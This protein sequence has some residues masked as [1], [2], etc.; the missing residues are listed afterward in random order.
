[1]CFHMWFE[2]WVNGRW[3]TLD[4]TLGQGHVG[5]GHVKVLDAHWNDTDSFLPLLPVVR[6]LGKLK[7]DVLSVEYQPSA[8]PR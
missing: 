2:V 3:Y 5:A 8:G 4:G 1:M 6:L 7:L